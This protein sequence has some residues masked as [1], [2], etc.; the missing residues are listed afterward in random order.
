MHPWLFDVSQ[1]LSHIYLYLCIVC[2]LGVSLSD[3]RRRGSILSCNNILLRHLH[4]S[5]LKATK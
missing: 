4:L 5:R 3:V 2:N 1:N